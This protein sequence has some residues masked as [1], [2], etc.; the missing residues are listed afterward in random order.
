MAPTAS[1][2]PQPA[3]PIYVRAD[4][5]VLR[6]PTLQGKGI[7]NPIATFWTAALMLDHLGEGEAAARLM[8]AVEHVMAAGILT[9]DVGG[10]ATTR[11][12]TNAVVDA[13]YSSN[14]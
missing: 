11:D 8:R 14:V 13:I 7:A 9:P 1:I 6:F 12:V 4:P 10:S 3:L 2:D 5:R